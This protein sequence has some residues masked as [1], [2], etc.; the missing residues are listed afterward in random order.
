MLP[1]AKTF[2]PAAA[3]CID[4]G[5]KLFDVLDPA[6]TF[7]ILLEADAA[8]TMTETPYKY[9]LMY[10]MENDNTQVGLDMRTVGTM[11]GLA[12]YEKCPNF[13]GVQ[14]IKAQ[15][16][17]AAF[18]VKSGVFSAVRPPNG[19]MSMW[20]ALEKATSPVTKSLILGARQKS[21]G[22]KD[23]FWDGTLYQCVVYKSA[24]TDEQLKEWVTGG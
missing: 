20:G 2:T 9:T 6:P 1:E 15:K 24:L 7:T 3:E 10:C 4:T 14:A 5:V 11:V 18:R 8:E 23:R 16:Y 13:C 17:R 19:D 22:T 21:D 12:M